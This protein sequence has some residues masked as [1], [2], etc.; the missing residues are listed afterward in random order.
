MIGVEI[1]IASD[2]AQSVEEAV[3]AAFVGGASTVELCSAM[4]RD[5]L[6]PTK[7]QIEQARN[8]FGSRRGLMVMIRPRADGFSYSRQ[9]LK[10]MRRQIAMAAE[11]GAD[12]VV[13]G[14]LCAGDCIIDEIAL[15]D[16]VAT[17]AEF[18]LQVTFHRAFD[19]LANPVES[20]R[21]L[22]DAGVD[23]VLTSGTGWGLDQT[24]LNGLPQLKKIVEAADGRIEVVIGG[25]ICAATGPQVLKA[26]ITPSAVISLHAYSGVQEQGRTTLA[27]VQGLLCALQRF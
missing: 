21:I 2:G 14:A 22:I 7:E 16:L 17:S 11:S 18:D 3:T 13:L 23:R 10:V 24:A 6:T 26:L 20:V 19:A 15:H 4:H 5:G 8:A 12:G 1:C 27:G 25:G 9:E